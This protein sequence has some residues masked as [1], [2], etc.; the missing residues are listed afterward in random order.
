MLF[1]PSHAWDGAASEPGGPALW[2]SCVLSWPRPPFSIPPMSTACSGCV[3]QDSARMPSGEAASVCP[4][5]CS[6][7]GRA[8]RVGRSPHRCSLAGRRCLH[9]GVCPSDFLLH[10]PNRHICLLPRGSDQQKPPLEGKPREGGGFSHCASLCFSIQSWASHPFL[11]SPNRLLSD[12]RLVV[13]PDPA[14]FCEQTCSPLC[15]CVQCF[16]FC[17]PARCEPLCSPAGLAHLY[18]AFRPREAPGWKAGGLH[19]VALSGHQTTQTKNEPMLK[20]TQKRPAYAQPS[21][22]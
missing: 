17:P 4:P 5:A 9:V 1:Y 13:L 15:L 6:P 20:T 12:Q 3:S 19:S 8:D 10:G 22:S 18:S 14:T 21:A 2:R 16:P 11:T 7:H